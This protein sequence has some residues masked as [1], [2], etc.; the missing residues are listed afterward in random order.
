M[1]MLRLD[2]ELFLWLNA[3]PEDHDWVVEA[4]HFL[5]VHAHWVLLAIMLGLALRRWRPLLRPIAAALLAIGFG[6]LACDLIGLAWDR[7][8]PFERGLGH[9]HLPHAGSPS[10]PSSH[11]TVYAALACSFVLVSAYRSVGRIL[12][13]L[14][15]LVSLARV[16]VGVHYPLDIV[17]GGLLGCLAAVAAHRLL[18]RVAG[19]RWPAAA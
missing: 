15:G 2:R 9:L 4:G 19:P 1:P 11:A 5:A 10:F 17:I 13:V 8:R 3:E 12:L 6:S 7:P 14:A 18:D 16:V